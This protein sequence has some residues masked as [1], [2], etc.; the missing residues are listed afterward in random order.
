MSLAP[1]T[2]W[3]LA[4]VAWL[5]AFL[6]G[7]RSGHLYGTLGLMAA[8]LVVAAL[9]FSDEARRA[10]VPRARDVALGLA[11]GAASLV[12]THVAFPFVARLLP[13]LAAHVKSLYALA[14]VTPLVLVPVALIVVAEEL[15]WR[16]A[17]PRAL[18]AH[19]GPAASLT[20][21]TLLYA[22]AQLGAGSAWLALAA[23]GLG[24]LWSACAWWT[25][26]LAA[27]IVC[28]ATWTLGVLGFWPLPLAAM[29]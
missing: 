26:A 1:V 5:L 11:L 24:A 8:S 16:E 27:P 12:A 10:L 2:G 7:A 29:G 14:A 6:A 4:S 21:A 18:G 15:V 9:V 25:R 3:T 19:M 20:L 22:A 13:S 23:L 28:H 17:L